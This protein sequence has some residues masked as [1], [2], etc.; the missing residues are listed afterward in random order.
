MQV[1]VTG[2]DGRKYTAEVEGEHRVSKLKEQVAK[3]AGVRVE[4]VQLY[5]ERQTVVVDTLED[6]QT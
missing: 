4:Q 2:P 5:F 1:F 6:D 3:Q